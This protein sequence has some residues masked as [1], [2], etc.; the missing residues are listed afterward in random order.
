MTTTAQAKA[1]RLTAHAH[2]Y[3]LPSIPALIAYLHGTAGFPVKSTWLTAIKRGAYTSWPG[4][5]YTLAARYCPEADETLRGHMA[6]PRQHIRSMQTPATTAAPLQ[7]P[8]SPSEAN[9]S[10]ANSVEFHKLPIN[11]ILTDNTSR[12][13]P[14]ACSG[15]Q[16]IMVALHSNSNAILVR[17][18]ASKQDAHRIAAYTDIYT[19]LATANQAPTLHIMDN[20]ASA[21]LQRAITTNNCKIQLVPPHVHRRNTAECAI[22][23]FKDHFLA[24]IA[25]TDPMF[26]ADRWDLL[27]PHAELTLNLL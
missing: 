18:F 17:P 24:I 5:T 9:P 13:E 6:Q 11:S 19:R 1:N 12:F 23:T 3:D 7:R 20:E 15:N 21:A 16:Y 22:C 2:A 8:L 4:L 26:P 10:K 14:L 27:L 25:G